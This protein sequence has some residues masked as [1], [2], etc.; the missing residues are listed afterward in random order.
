LHKPTAARN[1][2]AVSV[3]PSS[4]TF[5]VV[6]IS[7]DVQKYRRLLLYIII[8]SFELQVKG[9]K[10]NVLF[11]NQIGDKLTKLSIF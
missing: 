11:F 7:L 10:G 9:K 3:S 6:D 5:P 1:N 4:D 2:F 8:D